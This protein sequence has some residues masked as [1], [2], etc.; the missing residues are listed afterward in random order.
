MQERLLGV[1]PQECQ[2][3]EAE[4]H[5]PGRTYSSTIPGN[6]SHLVLPADRALEILELDE[7]DR[8]HPREPRTATLLG[9]PVEQR[10]R[11]D[12]R[13]RGRIAA[14]VAPAQ[15]EARADE[16]DDDNRGGARRDQEI[17]V[18]A[19]FGGWCCSWLGRHRVSLPALGSASASQRDGDA[20]DVERPAV[21][22]GRLERDDRHGPFGVGKRE[23]DVERAPRPGPGG[24]RRE[25]LEESPRRQRRAPR[26][27]TVASNTLA[28]PRRPNRASTLRSPGKRRLDEDL[29][30]LLLDRTASDRRIDDDA[31]PADRLGGL[32]V[33]PERDAL[34]RREA[35]QR[36]DDL[37]DATEHR[38]AAATV[39]ERTRQVDRS[40]TP[41]ASE[42]S[43][44]CRF[45]RDRAR[46]A[47]RAL[48]V[49]GR[50]VEQRRRATPAPRRVS[51]ST[52]R[53]TGAIFPVAEVIHG[54]GRSSPGSVVC[55]VVRWSAHLSVGSRSLRRRRIRPR[56][57][58][59]RR[60][61]RRGQDEHVSIASRGHRAR[62]LFGNHVGRIARERGERPPEGG[63]ELE[64]VPGAGG[65]DDD[66]PV[67]LEDERLVGRVG[68]ETGL[69]RDRAPDR[70]R[71][72]GSQPRS[73]PSAPLPSAG[74]ARPDRPA[75]QSDAAPP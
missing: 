74:P 42:R 16:R 63:G 5:V 18:A 48:L 12:R 22:G 72:S 53:R 29:R 6:P 25:R 43:T 11:C 61:Q 55:G 47:R 32:A 36:R 68:V 64:P 54:D 27:E 66:P 51:I 75:S 9:D 17:P 28:V 71:G 15:E 39:V 7:R 45:R 2:P 14:A 40:P 57:R 60:R 38:R 30:G 4:L 73:T 20:E 19:S 49:V 52:V 24:R 70:A 50:P 67:S 34:D 10:R 31:F 23:L 13:R 33:E 35:G 69:R 65:C 58:T 41:S 59:Q 21:L 62:R 44:Q 3:D 56:R 37:R 1:R 8:P 46:E 26:C